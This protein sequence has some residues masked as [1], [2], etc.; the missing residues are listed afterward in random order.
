MNEPNPFILY[1]K[2]FVSSNPVAISATAAAVSSVLFGYPFDTVKTKMQAYKYSSTLNCI[3][4]TYNGEG[5]AGFF[6]GVFPVL[7]SA[8][9]FRSISF[10]IYTR[11]KEFSMQTLNK[12]TNL[13]VLSK[14]SLSSLS[15]GLFS[16]TVISC[17]NAPIEFV[18]IQ[19]QL[20]R[21]Y[22]ANVN[23]FGENITSSLETDAKGIRRNLGLS[24]NTTTYQW[25][26][27]IFQKRGLFG[28]YYGAHLHIFRDALGSSL[29]FC[30]YEITKYALTPS[31]ERPSSITTLLAGG[32]AGSS[33]WLI[34]FPID[35]VKSNIQK[36][37]LS[38][39][40]KY[41]SA[42]HFVK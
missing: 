11:T 30:G 26:V 37:A 19:K 15:S 28:L 31:G 18:K 10:T 34:L 5:I 1:S 22:P 32:F 27:K 42:R 9:V 29:Y 39:S 12:S 38:S 23:S 33:C 20:E 6:R 8:S 35:L 17:L 13:S 21:I 14:I 25:V 40:P 4:Q 7:F 41:T 36:E 2:N 24:N 3:K 16:G